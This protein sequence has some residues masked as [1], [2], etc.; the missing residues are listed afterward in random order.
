ME[1]DYQKQQKAK[2]LLCKLPIIDYAKNQFRY[3]GAADR[4]GKVSLFKR[5]RSSSGSKIGIVKGH[6]SR[7]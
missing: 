5:R 6:T 3:G 2:A 1:Q 4:G 7:N